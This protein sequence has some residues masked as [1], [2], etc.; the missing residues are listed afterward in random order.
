ML[1]IFTGLEN[2]LQTN[3]ENSTLFLI[4][5]KATVFIFSERGKKFIKRKVRNDYVIKKCI[6]LLRIR[7]PWVKATK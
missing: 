4:I 5:I 3:K 2:A 1:R 6:G 7:I